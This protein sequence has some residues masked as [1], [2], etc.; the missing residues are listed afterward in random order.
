ME[1]GPPRRLLFANE[2]REGVCRP[3]A[4]RVVRL[5]TS[6]LCELPVW[7][8]GCSQLPSSWADLKGSDRDLATYMARWR[9]SC[10]WP[11][12]S[13]RWLSRD[14]PD[15]VVATPGDGGGTAF[16]VR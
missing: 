8:F 1:S 13:T 15:N 9:F 10:T 7:L 6:T 11:D 16:D 5:D 2:T 4:R 12:L 3:G 14:E